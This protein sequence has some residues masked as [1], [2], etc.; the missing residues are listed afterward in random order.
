MNG[1]SMGYECIVICAIPQT[2]VVLAKPA[3]KRPRSKLFPDNFWISYPFIHPHP[4]QSK[5]PVDLAK[6]EEHL[7]KRSYV[8]G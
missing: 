7:A 2:F 5:M 8:E 4:S 1:F 3:L 6:L